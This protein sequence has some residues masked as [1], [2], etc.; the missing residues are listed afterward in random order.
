MKKK[1]YLSPQMKVRNLNAHQMLC[2]SPS[3]VETDELNYDGTEYEF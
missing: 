3:V 1:H 2:A